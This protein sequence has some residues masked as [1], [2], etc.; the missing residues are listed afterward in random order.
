[1]LLGASEVW[2]HG[3]ALA[4]MADLDFEEGKGLSVDEMKS[5]AAQA[6]ICTTSAHCDTRCAR[7][8]NPG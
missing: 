3:V 5:F 6:R 1:M 8:D 4:G 2:H 7:A